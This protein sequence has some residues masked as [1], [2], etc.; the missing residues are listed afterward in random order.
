MPIN[1]I[2]VETCVVCVQWQR[3]SVSHIGAHSLLSVFLLGTTRHVHF[4][5]KF[6]PSYKTTTN[7]TIR[8]PCQKR[9]RCSQC[10]RL[11]KRNT[12][13]RRIVGQ[14]C[15]LNLAQDSQREYQLFRSL[16]WRRL[17]KSM[18]NLLI[19]HVDT[20]TT[21]GSR[22]VVV[23]KKFVC[24]VLGWRSKPPARADTYCYMYLLYDT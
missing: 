3:Q 18:V 16:L 22:Y 19:I 9:E 23:S 12:L 14:S 24:H 2:S 17:L 6:S 8:V 20:Y 15:T 7:M 11:E 21:I 1:G 10:R 13:E 5:A 4:V